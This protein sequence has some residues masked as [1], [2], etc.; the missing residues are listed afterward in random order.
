MIVYV[1]ATGQ[2]RSTALGRVASHFYITAETVEIFTDPTT[3]V[4]EYMADTG[5]IQ[6]ETH[7]A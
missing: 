6:P 2:I 5:A 1:E 7:T 4:S 3:G